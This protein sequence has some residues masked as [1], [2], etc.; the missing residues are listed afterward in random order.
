MIHLSP[1]PLRILGTNLGW[2]T[3]SGASGT[4]LDNLA[5]IDARLMPQLHCF[6]NGVIALNRN[7]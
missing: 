1:E 5:P 7:N 6:L 3:L 2:R 4:V